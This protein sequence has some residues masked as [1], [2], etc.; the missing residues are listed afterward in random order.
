MNDQ[1]DIYEI[2]KRKKPT[3]NKQ[4]TF[5]LYIEQKAEEEEKEKDVQ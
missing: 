1:F 4:I 3:Y 5:L 2:D